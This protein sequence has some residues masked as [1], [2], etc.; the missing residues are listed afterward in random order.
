MGSA[1][2]DTNTVLMWLNAQSEQWSHTDSTKLKTGTAHHFSRR[3]SMRWGGEGE[4]TSLLHS[5]WTHKWCLYWHD[6][7]TMKR[8]TKHPGDVTHPSWWWSTAF[9]S[10]FIF[11]DS[12]TKC[13]HHMLYFNI[14]QWTY[15]Y[16]MTVFH[17]HFWLVS[18]KKNLQVDPHHGA[19]CGRQDICDI[20]ESLFTTF[21]I[22]ISFFFLIWI[23]KCE[24]PQ[25][26]KLLREIP[27]RSF[28]STFIWLGLENVSG[29]CLQIISQLLS[30][31]FL[32]LPELFSLCHR[33]PVHTNGPIHLKQ[34]YWIIRFSGSAPYTVLWAF[35]NV[36]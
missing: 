16:T 2:D 13:K 8:N 15:N 35:D 19:I 26:W 6:S 27:H 20:L 9:G 34:V 14:T 22:L 33:S 1:A 23:A 3:P 11:S 30:I 7:V 28:T 5:M 21:N 17:I 4:N 25:E 31:S 10:Q 29:G 36:Q 18:L 24:T 12:L 32:T